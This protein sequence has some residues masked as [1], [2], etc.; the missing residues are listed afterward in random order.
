MYHGFV[1]LRL[2]NVLLIHY[3]RFP[4]ESDTVYFFSVVTPY[5]VHSRDLSSLFIY[6]MPYIII[7]ALRNIGYNFPVTVLYS[8][9]ILVI[10]IVSFRHSCTL[11]ASE[12][13]TL[14]F[15][16]LHTYKFVISVFGVRS[17]Q[18]FLISGYWMLG[19]KSARFRYVVKPHYD[20]DDNYYCNYKAHI[21]KLFHCRQNA[22][23][24]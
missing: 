8:Y 15:S 7:R 13:F 9:C 5:F 16:V 21:L 3:F 14:Q 12:V 20:G 18:P 6:S 4:D 22:E 17:F 11:M 1:N 2:L 23:Y 10:R 19:S 24:F